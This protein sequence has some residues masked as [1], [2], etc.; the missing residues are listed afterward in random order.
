MLGN[1]GRLAV[2]DDVVAIGNQLGLT[3]STTAGVVSGLDRV[4]T[5]ERRQPASPG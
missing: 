4:A 2:G 3:S 5:G 1:S